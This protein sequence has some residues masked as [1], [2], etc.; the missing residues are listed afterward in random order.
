MV[1]DEQCLRDVAQYVLS[2]MGYK[3]ILAADGESAI[4]L[5]KKGRL[6][7]SLIVLDLI[8]PGM[9]GMRC[10][11][12]LLKMDPDARIIVVSGYTDE[13]PPG[14]FLGIGAR[15]FVTK[16]YDMVGLSKVIR[17]VMDN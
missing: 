8:M 3:V 5:Y 4:E 14:G 6:D 10:L 7:I 2:K 12:Q 17:K 16:P 15:E 9:G 1:D 13:Q 11:E